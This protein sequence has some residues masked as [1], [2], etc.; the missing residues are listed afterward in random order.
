VTGGPEVN[1][2][3][4]SLTRPPLRQ[5][6]LRRGL[7]EG[8]AATWRALDVVPVTGSTNADVAARARA[9][10]PGGYVLL[11]DEQTAGRGRRDRVW[12]SPARSGLAM[13]VLLRP[14]VPVAALGWVPL[15]G[16]LAVT[17]ALRTVCGLQA[18]LK[19]P[20]D[21][22][23]PVP[24]PVTGRLPRD[25]AGKVAGLLAEAVPG[26][27]PQEVGAVVLGI[28]LNVS[29][30]AAELP[31]PQATSLRLAGSATTDRDTVA[32]AVLRALAERYGAWLAAGGDP[33]A[34]G[35][36][37]AYRETCVTIGRP[38][39][40]LLPD[41]STL[42]GQA[43]GVDDEG[44]LLVRPRRAGRA[45]S[46]TVLPLSAGDVVHVRAEGA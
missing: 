12:E 8:P 17:E 18:A 19:W 15:L 40:V 34:S 36:A 13:S 3:W 20:N 39:Q 28:G 10:E 7:V 46:E 6:A 25:P 24:D 38:V 5:E 44:R 16:G 2:S 35:I 1:G 45:E 22:L 31:V 30:D 26:A 29:Q 14:A 23:V 11:A 42:L 9:G 33:V 21:V 4:S 32:R 37:S 27:G 43:E 41:S